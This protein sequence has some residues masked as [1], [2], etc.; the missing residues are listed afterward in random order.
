VTVRWYAPAY[1][2][3]N[4]NVIPCATATVVI[5]HARDS[6]EQLNREWMVHPESPE[7]FL[8]WQDISEWQ[9]MAAA[10]VQAQEEQP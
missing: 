1:R 6:V 5:E 2:A 10:A 9:P 8:A 3:A 4:G 7:V